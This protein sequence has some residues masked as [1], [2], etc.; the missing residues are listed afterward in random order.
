MPKLVKAGRTFSDALLSQYR[1]V[2]DPAADAVIDRLAAE[3]GR[4]ALGE[5][6]R[7]LGDTRRHL[8]HSPELPPV[9]QGFFMRHNQLPAWAN[10]RQMEQG[11]RFFQQHTSAI[12][13]TLGCY[14]LPYCYAG[15]D[16]AR[17]LWLSERIH[18][19]TRKRLE[20]TGEW[21]FTVTKKSAWES[22]EA[23]E[24]TLRV[25][26]MHAAIRYF[27]LHSGQWDMA[28]GYPVNQ[29]DMCGTS[30]AF[31]YIVIRG[32][33]KAGIPATEA[34]EE[35]YLHLINVVGS[36]MGVAD[37]LLPR[38]LREAF[39]LDRAI[40]QRQFRPSEPGQGLTRS[41]LAALEEAAP[42][43]LRNLPAAQMRFFLG[44]E[45]A[46]DLGIPA[47]PLEKRLVGLASALP[48]FRFL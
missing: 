37:E 9:V 19:D 38:N 27:T 1:Q 39:H 34:E 12:A 16:G 24:R 22:G 40:A 13:L 30:G 17:V 32:L 18:R 47:V 11:M 29:E 48:V 21:I 28:W 8:A 3:G 35:A 44:D 14:S 7:W 4:E 26:L 6:M 31:S 45:L 43:P 25:R 15:A 41:L 46:D 23:V 33:R 42:A 10:I 20:E 5:L 2:G 36:L